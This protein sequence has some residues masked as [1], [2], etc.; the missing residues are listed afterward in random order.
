MQPDDVVAFVLVLVVALI[1][2]LALVFG[3]SLFVLR[4]VARKKEANARERYPAAR[5]IDRSASFFG[6]E[7]R[8]GTQ[9]RGNG[10]LILTD[11]ELIFEQWVTNKKIRIPLRNIQ[12]LENPKSFLGKSRFAPLLKVVY[13]NEQGGKDAM[14]WQVR[15][16]DDWMQLINDARA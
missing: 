9:M 13:I 7:S 5:H 10:I 15:N 3:G 1:L 14:A 4:N 2:V 16:L 8:G 11:S 12:V 6:Q